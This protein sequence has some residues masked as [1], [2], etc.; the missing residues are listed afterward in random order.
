MRENSTVTLKGI[1]ATQYTYQC[2]ERRKSKIPSQVN[3][4]QSEYPAIMLKIQMLE[5]IVTSDSVAEQQQDEREQQQ[6]Q[7]QRQDQVSRSP[8]NSSPQR[9]GLVSNSL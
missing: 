3:T 1:P 2:A 4:E 5:Q 6:Q 7:Q 8:L 9:E